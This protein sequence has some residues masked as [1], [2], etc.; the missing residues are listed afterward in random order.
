M[1]VVDALGHGV[2]A[3]AEGRAVSTGRPV[4][5]HG[6]QLLLRDTDELG[7]EFDDITGDMSR[8]GETTWR[9][10]V[11]DATGGEF[12]HLDRRIRRGEE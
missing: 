10:V 1:R 9:D 7:E 5:R 3:S 8:D 6:R 2:Q 4:V 11:Q 12:V